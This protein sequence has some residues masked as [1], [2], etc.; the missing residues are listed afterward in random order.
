M[1]TILLLAIACTA[2]ACTEAESSPD[3]GTGVTDHIA[4]V[5]ARL[6]ATNRH[7]WDAWEALHTPDAIRTAPELVEPLVGAGAM[8]AA[9]EGLVTAFPD[10]H[11]ELRQAFG[12]GDWL[13]A[14]IHT[15]ATHTGPLSLGEATIPA[16]GRA[17]EQDWVAVIRFDG[18]R[19]AELHET[20]DQ[21]A[22]I[23]QLGLERA[24]AG[25]PD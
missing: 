13:T 3:A 17:I 25:C 5:E 24:I 1:K 18:D 15:T 21:Y 8:R 22:L 4:I 14:T 20:Y 11:L 16:T 6:D 7:D 2:T 10:Y 12:S 19:I 9:I 23:L